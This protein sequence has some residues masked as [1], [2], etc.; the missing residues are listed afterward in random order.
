MEAII[1]FLIFVMGA[2]FGSFFTLAVYRI[3]IGE[4]I[5]HKHSF[6][7]NCNHKLGALDLIPIFSYIFLRGKCRYCHKP[8]RIRYFLL[9]VLSGFTFLAFALSLRFNFYDIEIGKYVYFGFAILY[10]CTLFM[11]AGIDKERRTIQ[12]SVFIFGLFVV[13]RIYV[14]SIHTRRR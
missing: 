3:P 8:I 1:Y 5:T 12:K 11:I 4:D 13:A 9:E 2:F 14:I 7:P 10:L 6:C